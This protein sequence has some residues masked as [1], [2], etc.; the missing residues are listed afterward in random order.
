MIL[1][2]PILFLAVVGGLIA[3]GVKAWRSRG[4]PDQEGGLDLIPYL[5]LALAVGVAGFSLAR[6]ARASLTP[7]RLAGRPIGELAGALAGLVVAG[8][9]AFVLWRV[10]AK[11]RTAF[12]RNPGWPIYLAAI[13]VVFLSAFFV[14]VGQVADALTGTA[15]TPQWTDLAVYG[16]IVG[17]HWWAVNRETPYGDVGELPRLIGSAVSAVALAVGSIGTLTWLLSEAYE[18]LGGSVTVPEP[19]ITLALLV[20]AGPVWAWRWLPVWEGEP[21]VLRNV[22]LSAATALSL[23]MTIG[24]AV[25]ITAVLISFLAGQAEPAERHFDVYPAALSFVIVGSGLWIHHRGRIGDER[26]GALRG[27][28]YAVAA[29]G[30][31]TLIGFIVALVNLVFAPRLAGGETG[32]ALIFLGCSVIASGAAWAWFWR[33]VQAAPRADEIHSLPRRMY[34]LGM[35]VI[36]GLTAAG[37][38]IALLIVVFRALLG[39]GGDVS[40]SLRIP[41]TLTVASGLAAW[42]LFTHVRA[43]GAQLSKT[44]VEPFTVTV[45]CSRPGPLS[46]LFPKEATVRVMYRA[47]D[48]GMIDEAMAAAIVSEV[49]GRSSLVWVDDRG[50]RVAAAREP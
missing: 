20:T 19:A 2:G 10:Q 4:E 26:G 3:L 29:T 36:T 37:A 44:E 40:D 9:I 6:L 1:L 45:V 31:A 23:L 42:H 38:L 39:E 22:Y 30:L 7:D 21:G 35:A 49:G 25:T 50:F 46:T 33:K 12:L 5:I 16:G 27:Y 43:D 28:Q 14:S 11:K 17:F 34:L 8:P 15:L 18:S 32:E 41:A 13:E 24:A 47:D 48:S